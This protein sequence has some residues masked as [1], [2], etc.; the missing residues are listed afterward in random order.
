MSWKKYDADIKDIVLWPMGMYKD[1]QYATA[2]HNVQPVK[3]LFPA[4]IALGASFYVFGSPFDKSGMDMAIQYL[5]TG[6]IYY[7]SEIL[8]KDDPLIPMHHAKTST[9]QGPM[10]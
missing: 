7:A 6:A 10:Y 8:L 5:S 4:A 2:T 3:R 1:I 9:H